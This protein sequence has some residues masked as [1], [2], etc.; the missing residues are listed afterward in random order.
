MPLF[1]LISGF[2]YRIEPDAKAYLIGKCAHLLV[3]YAV[4]LLLLSGIQG[5]PLLVS[6]DFR[7]LGRLGGRVLMG[8]RYLTDWTGVFWFITCLFLTQQFA[9]WAFRNFEE[10]YLWL[11]SGALVLLAFATAT[12]FSAYKLPWN[13][14]KVLFAFPLFFA[15]WKF[16]STDSVDSLAFFFGS[17][18]LSTLG[19]L[20]VSFGFIETIDMK[21]SFYGT[22]FVS[23]FFA[24]CISVS[25]MHICKLLPDGS[26]ADRLLS[27]VGKASMAIMFLHQAVNF[28]LE[29][30]GLRVLGVRALAA[31]IL[32]L[33]F[34]YFC[35]QFRFTN[36]FFLGSKADLFSYLPMLKSSMRKN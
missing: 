9:N 30:F 12:F 22:A 28:A 29:D 32:P 10:R 15:G 36:A 11:L 21:R 7:E 2:L 6:G 19:L 25:L 16:R 20:L 27:G 8:G 14:D 13:A 5:L 35:V 18:V 26:V 33:L 1:F 4:F 3:P 23:V 31:L 17:V 34:Y 24:I